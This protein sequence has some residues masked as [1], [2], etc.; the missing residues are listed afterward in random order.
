MLSVLLTFLVATPAN[1]DLAVADDALFLLQNFLASKLTRTRLESSEA[2][3]E[4]GHGTSAAAIAGSQAFRTNSS[5]V[6]RTNSNIWVG[7]TSSAR[8][9]QRRYTIRNTWMHFTNELNGGIEVKFVLCDEGYTSGLR[10][11][12]IQE[13]EQYSDMV[14][15]D[16]PEGYAQGL[17]TKKVHASMMYFLGQ[18]DEHYDTFMKADDDAFVFLP[19]LLA[20]VR[21]NTAPNF[22]MGQML[23]SEQPFRDP[24]H[25]WYEPVE[26][27]PGIWPRAASGSG[28][29]LDRALLSHMLVD[30]WQHI[31]RL[32]LFNEDKAIGKW[33]KFEVEERGRQ[34]EYVDLP[35]RDGVPKT[36]KPLVIYHHIGA[37]AMQCLWQKVAL[38][39][40]S[41]ELCQGR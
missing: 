37:T 4:Q 34:V 29:L 18:V 3:E 12:L 13:Y 41:A 40:A 19:E 14:V 6:A 21:R 10:A 7:I 9:F 20:T 27:W 8:N 1:A 36:Q 11:Q 28:Y 2:A 22:Y 33:V 38:H 24:K 30:D 16:C 32:F 25:K 23:E 5:T 17:L 39:H 35:G 26:N 15:L 31:K